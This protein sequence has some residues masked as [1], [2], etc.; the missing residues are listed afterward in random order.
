MDE[1]ITNYCFI[2]WTALLAV[3]ARKNANLGTLLLIMMIPKTLDVLVLTPLLQGIKTSDY[4]SLFFIVHSLNDL[5]MI[6]LIKHRW[7]FANKLTKRVVYRKL[8]IESFI[9]HIYGV[10][11]TYNLL[12]FS[13][14]SFIGSKYFGLPESLFYNNYSGIKELITGVEA[15]ILTVLTV[16]TI[17]VIR[18]LKRKG[19]ID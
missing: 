17:I 3:L 11:I 8:K 2:A 15:I 12:V 6:T 19:L 13:D 5:L 4:R 16:Q 14:Y 10:S 18:Q 9:S 7:Y 1:I